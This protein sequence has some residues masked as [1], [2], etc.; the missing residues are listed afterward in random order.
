MI[1]ETQFNNA[2]DFIADRCA[3]A[4]DEK[5]LA[6]YYA[7]LSP[8]LTTD[9]FLEAA[10]SVWSSAEFFPPPIA[11]MKVRAESEWERLAKCA[12]LHTPPHMQPG[13]MEAYE[14]LD[15]TTI[16][17][18]SKM[19]GIPAFKDKHLNRDP[20]RA[21]DRFRKEY[22]AVLETEAGESARQIEDR[23]ERIIGG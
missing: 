21:M 8:R 20:V 2:M 14:A 7:F 22:T 23:H 19:G 1:D 10:K 18:L 17:T 12:R 15:S 9:E 5:Q 16:R 11:F 4:P 13:Y 3:K 6:M